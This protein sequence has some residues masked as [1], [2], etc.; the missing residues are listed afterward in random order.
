MREPSSPGP[1][2][3]TPDR[4]RPRRRATAGGRAG[5]VRLPPLA[6][7]TVVR[8]RLHQRLDDAVDRPV[9]LV[10]APPGA[11]KTMLLSAWLDA[12]AHPGPVAA[13]WVAFDR[14]CDSLGDVWA[15]FVAAFGGAA[16]R[17]AAPA[18]V[19]RMAERVAAAVE[20]A[21][22]RAPF[23]LVVDDLQDAEGAAA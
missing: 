6:A 17:G 19:E 14:S 18:T 9:T 2:T 16:L 22:G 4:R 3:P 1:R 12:R 20:A 13:A 8:Q 21:P 5:A 15:R 23:V 10:A 7:G 11:G